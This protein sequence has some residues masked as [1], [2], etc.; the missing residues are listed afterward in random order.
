MFSVFKQHYTYFHILFHPHIFLHVFSNNK[1]HVFKYMY[2][3][4]QVYV[5]K[6]TWRAIPSSTIRS[7][8]GVSRLLNLHSMLFGLVVNLM[9]SGRGNR[10][11]DAAEVAPL[12]TLRSCYH[13]SLPTNITWNFSLPWLGLSGLR[14][15]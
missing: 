2:Q 13:G 7:A 9:R 12:W 3:T 10:S 15:T 5:Q 1:T 14:G 6:K 11:G 4:L 8:I